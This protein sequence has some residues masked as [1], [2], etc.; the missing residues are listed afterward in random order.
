MD[1]ARAG[2][3]APEEILETGFL[4]RFC[5]NLLLR[6][7]SRI[8]EGYLELEDERRV[9]H[10]YGDPAASLQAR[11]TIHDGRIWRLGL[12]RGEVGL[13][14]G[15]Q[16]G[17]WSSPDPVSVAR[18]AV[19]NLQAFE[20]KGVLSWL[21][22]SLARLRH[23]F[24][25]NTRHGSRANIRAHYDLGNAFYGLWL[26]ETLAYS[27][28][29]YASAEDSLVQAQ[30]NKF[31]RLARMLDLQ[32]ED[33]LLEIGTGWGGFALH[34]ASRFGCRVTTT[35]ISGEQLA[36]AKVRVAE[37]GLQDRITLLQQDY[38]DL[39]GHYDKVVSIE[40]FEAVGLEHYDA[41][42][43]VL[44][45]VLKPGGRAAIQTITM[46]ESHFEAYVRSTDWIQQHIFPGAELA[47]LAEILKSL[48]RV[49]NLNLVRLED[50]GRHYAR[51]LKTWRERFHAQIDQVKALGYDDTFVRTWDYYLAYCEGAFLERY[52]SDVQLLLVKRD[53]QG[54]LPGEPWSGE[55]SP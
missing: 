48:G 16:Q 25:G 33:H 49:T 15:Y 31:E 5:R 55:V 37:A 38:R 10:R 30:T 20:T 41:F 52:I 8:R 19:R 53:Y 32:P 36:L 4:N 12:F 17:Y 18:L 47:G 2:I 6:S 51:T 54:C 29:V 39:Q 9:V 3:P 21:G 35:T 42:F 24:H 34:A 14:E 45:R 7:L 22:R 26:D 1:Q 40:M 27:A 13:G 44:D 50:I 23:R 46:N 43:Q 11:A 28:A